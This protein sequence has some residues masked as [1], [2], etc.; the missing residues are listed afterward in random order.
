[1]NVRSSP[2]LLRIAWRNVRRNA[3]HSLGTILAIAVGFV[4]ISVFDGYLT[5]LDNDNV[6][7]YA[8]LFMMG[9]L[10]VEPVGAS[11]A[12][13]GVA[14]RV[15]LGEREQA[16]VEE[17]LAS[18]PGEVV[19]RMPMLY[20]WGFASAGKATARFITFSYDPADGVKLRRRFAWNALAGKP[21]Q[22]AGESSILLEMGLGGLLDCE[23]TGHAPA[24]RKDGSMIAEERPFACRRPRVQLVASTASGQLNAVEPEV[25]GLIDGGLKDLDAKFAHIPL[26]LGQKLLDTK[27]VSQI[28]VLLRDPARAKAFARDLVEAARARGLALVAVP[29]RDHVNGAEHRRGMRVFAV[30]RALMAVIVVLVAAMTVL[31][32]MA[33]AVSER[34]REIGTL[35]SI[36]FLRR[37]VVMLFALEAALLATIASAIGLAVTVATVAALNASGITYSAGLMA[38]P[39]TLGVSYLPATWAGAAVFLA[40]VAAAAAV[41]PAR[42]AARSRIP[43][44]LSHV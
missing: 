18:R 32:T 25:V 7:M 30:F 17:F 5:Y 15:L 38:Q 40:V 13:E 22:L 12:D 1:V 2:P 42:R 9:D 28:I 3:R 16:F 31:T 6:D 20:T 8:D 44:A 35:R 21:L 37:H 39:M 41:V 10:I 11:D 24:K 26:A 33:R 19:A 14:G 27:S 36:G 29:W 43:D 34:T 23:P 4:A